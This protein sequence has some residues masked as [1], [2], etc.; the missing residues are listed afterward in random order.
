M[1]VHKI[2]WCV[3]MAMAIA[4]TA[5]SLVLFSW[6]Q[7]INDRLDRMEKHIAF[8]SMRLTRRVNDEHNEWIKA[9]STLRYDVNRVLVDIKQCRIED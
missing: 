4:S 3:V 8:L 5:L 7:G 2:T 6:A 9:V 1:K